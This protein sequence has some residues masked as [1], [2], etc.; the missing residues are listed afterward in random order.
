MN[1]EHPVFHGEW[2]TYCNILR[3]ESQFKNIL[4]PNRN[5]GNT[6][7]NHSQSPKNV[8]YFYAL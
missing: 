8:L 2:V 4:Y 1:Y 6:T 7:I 5:L 3:Q